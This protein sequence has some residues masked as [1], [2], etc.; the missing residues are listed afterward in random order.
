MAKLLHIVGSPRG[1]RSASIT[2]A[3]VSSRPTRPRIPATTIETL[4]LWKAELPEF[5]GDDASTPST[6]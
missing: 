5:D 4:D 6:R 1:D 3:K 2:V